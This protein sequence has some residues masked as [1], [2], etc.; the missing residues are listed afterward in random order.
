MIIAG[1]AM[2]IVI[3]ISSIWYFSQNK[4]SAEV[5]YI[6]TPILNGR[7]LLYQL[8][9]IVDRRFSLAHT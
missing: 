4:V 2:I 9:R 1:S 6:K 7:G 8:L 5:K 3:I